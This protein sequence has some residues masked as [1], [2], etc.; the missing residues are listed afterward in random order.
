L[1]DYLGTSGKKQHHIQDAKIKKNLGLVRL[2]RI[3]GSEQFPARLL[4]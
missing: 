1:L 3:G 4:L 2:C